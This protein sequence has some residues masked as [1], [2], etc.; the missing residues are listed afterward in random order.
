MFLEFKLSIRINLTAN[1]K[2]YFNDAS[3]NFNYENYNCFLELISAKDIEENIEKEKISYIRKHHAIS[4][5]IEDNNKGTI[6]NFVK[7]QSMMQILN[8]VNSISNRCLLVIR[9][10]GNLTKVKEFS[11]KL[12]RADKE[13]F[14]SFFMMLDVKIAKNNMEYEKIL[15]HWGFKD[16]IA[17]EFTSKFL[18]DNFFDVYHE[19]YLDY[20]TWLDIKNALENNYE[21]TED[22]IFFVNSLEHRKNNNIRLAVIETVIGLEIVVTKYLRNYLKFK[23]IPN[24]RIGDLINPHIGIY[25]M[26]S[27][28]LDLSVEE[29]IIKHIKIDKVLKLIKLRNNVIHNNYK[30]PKETTKQNEIFEQ[31]QATHFLCKLLFSFCNKIIIIKG[32]LKKT[33]KNY[34]IENVQTRCMIDVPNIILSVYLKKYSNELITKIN[35]SVIN[36]L[37]DFRRFEKLYDEEKYLYISYRFNKKVMAKFSKG[38]LEFLNQ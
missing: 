28:L 8:L 31:I 1:E 19:E 10:Y 17:K 12:D 35:F 15:K 6:E 18:L 38:K 7:E 11:L 27:V 24:D 25:S 2:E 34:D 5:T 3:I 22:R 30:I 9:N 23:N 20:D 32:L 33:K 13:Q 4:I 26:V 37:K 36:S 14:K 21:I 29:E 16:D